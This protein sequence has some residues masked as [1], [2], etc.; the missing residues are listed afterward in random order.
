M[1]TSGTVVMTLV[2]ILV[3]TVVAST[4][5]PKE[6][7]LNPIKYLYTNTFET[8]D[9]VIMEHE[10]KV[11]LY[12]YTG[13]PVTS[14]KW[15]TFYDRRHADARS[16]VLGLLSKTHTLHHKIG[17]IKFISDEDL[18]KLL[19]ELVDANIIKELEGERGAIVLQH[20]RILRDALLFAFV[21]KKGGVLIP[22]NALLLQSTSIIWE[23]VLKSPKETIFVSVSQG[24]DEYGCPII[25]TRGETEVC[26]TIVAKMFGAGMMGEFYGGISFGGGS[27]LILKRLSKLGLNIHDVEGVE[28]VKTDEIIEMSP[29]PKKLQNSLIVVIP[30]EQGSG[31][32]SI[33]K[34]DLWFYSE[35]EKGIMK[36][37][38][39]FRDIYV[40]SIRNSKGV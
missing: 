24:N 36:S 25:A 23:N 17:D 28:Y 11:P 14:R 30:F 13:T 33:P 34:R 9:A 1:N 4:V 26:D 19:N 29:A 21:C 16:P 20:N 22:S 2:G 39:I 7:R 3:V 27:S 15:S 5:L 31:E 40:Q 10:K 18:L 6:H 37:P 12:V 38:S 35:S 8:N 32:T